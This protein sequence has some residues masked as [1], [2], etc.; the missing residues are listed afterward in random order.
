[1]LKPPVRFITFAEDLELEAVRHLGLSGPSRPYIKVRANGL[2]HLPKA[3]SNLTSF[4]H[5]KKALK[6]T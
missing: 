6:N 4:I 1:M 2:E 5:M 3:W